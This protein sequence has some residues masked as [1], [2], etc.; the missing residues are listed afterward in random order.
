MGW[1]Q[2]QV[3]DWD[4]TRY[5]LQKEKSLWR[6]TWHKIELPSVNREPVTVD[7]IVPAEKHLRKPTRLVVSLQILG[8]NDPV[9]WIIAHYFA[10]RGYPSLVVHRSKELFK[11]DFEE[12]DLK[13]TLQQFEDN[14][15]NV[16]I[17]HRQA[18]DFAIWY[19]D[20]VLKIA[21]FDPS[22]VYAVGVSLG[23][24]TLSALSIVE[25][26][27]TKSVIIMGGGDAG[28]VLAKSK[29]P[30]V[31]RNVDSLCAYYKITR[32]E[33][34]TQIKKIVKTDNVKM[35]YKAAGES[36]EIESWRYR[37]VVSLFD[38]QV[39]TSCQ[40]KLRKLLDCQAWYI[41]T[42]HYTAAVFLPMIL[43]WAR[44]FFERA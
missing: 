8:G 25:P 13:D 15:R 36:G 40:K 34:R 6:R 35:I 16:A 17:I 10:L 37:L 19:I 27:I 11:L 42:G 2:Y 39:P 29:E 32:E 5:N 28:D 31:K 44:R 21:E 33:L 7:I 9:S 1:E 18:I 20:A 43:W 4:K 22:E 30:S 12:H 14:L 24:I 23:G 41:P 26:R 3:P 38:T